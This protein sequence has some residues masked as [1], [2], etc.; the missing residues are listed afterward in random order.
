MSSKFGNCREELI[1]EN[2][3]TDKE[4]PNKHSVPSLATAHLSLLIYA[5][6]RDKLRTYVSYESNYGIKAY[7]RM[8]LLCKF[9]SIPF[10]LRRNLCYLNSA[11][12]RNIVDIK[13]YASNVK[14]PFNALDEVTS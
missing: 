1:A 10:F 6:A 4:K 7:S 13:S 11:L 14:K 2:G 5:R 8:C 9:K 12:L 3:L